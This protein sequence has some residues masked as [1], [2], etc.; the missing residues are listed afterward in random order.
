MKNQNTIMGTVLEAL[1]NL[2]YRVQFED[3]K[4]IRCYQAGKMKKAK[5]RIVIG[6]SV[7][8]VHTPEMG[9]IGRIVWRR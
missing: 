8:V 4:V 1:P 9:E 7:E 5:I 2:E 3:G 6:D